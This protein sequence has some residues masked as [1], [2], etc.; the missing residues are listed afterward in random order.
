MAKKPEQKQIS[1][2]MPPP[3][4][5][6]ALHLGH[7]LNNF[8]QDALI[9]YY[10]LRN[11]QTIWIPGFDHAGIAT[12]IMVRKWM[13]TKQLKAPT[14][15]ERADLFQK[16]SDEQKTKIRQ[17][18]KKLDLK[19]N[20][21]YE[22]FTLDPAF[23]VV[24]TEAFTQLYEK[25]LIYQAKTLVNWDPFLE[26]AIADIEVDHRE[27]TTALYYFKYQLADPKEK[28]ETLIVATTRPETIFADQAVFVHPDDERYQ[29]YH[30]KYVINPLNQQ[31]LP[32]LTDTKI[33]RTF[34]SG[35]LKCTPGHDWIDWELGKKFNL[36]AINCIDARGYLNHLGLKYANK[37][38]F[39]ARQAIVS[40]AKKQGLIVKIETYQHKIP[41]SSRSGVV[42]EPLLSSQW[43]LKT[44]QWGQKLL[45]EQKNMHIQPN[46]YRK[47]LT[48]WLLKM[49]DWCIS[50][51]L[52]W[53]HQLPVYFHRQTQAIKVSKTPLE[54]KTWRRSSDVLDTWFSSA[55]WAVA[56]LGWNFPARQKL[57]QLYPLTY[58]VTS[59][60]IIF[61][62]VIKMLFFGLEFKHE[63]PFKNLIIHGLIRTKNHL[64]MSKSRGNVVNP[65]ELI[66]KYGVDALRW[67]FLTGYKIGDDLQFETEKIIQA[68]Q[69]V[70]KISNIEKF[71]DRFWAK[72]ETIGLKTVK[73]PLNAWLLKALKELDKNYEQHYPKLNFALIGDLLYDFIWKKFS[74]F[75]LLFCKALQKG[76]AANET[77]NFLKFVWQKLLC[78]LHPF[79]SQSSEK[80]FIKTFG[81]SLK[82]FQIET[83][84]P[85]LDCKT[86]KI[87]FF[88][89][90]LTQ[91]L[92]LKHKTNTKKNKEVVLASEGKMTENDL[93]TLNRLLATQKL[94]ITKTVIAKLTKL[95]LK[96]ASTD[97]NRFLIEQKIAALSKEVLRSE[98]ILNNQQFLS[99]AKATIVQAEKQ[100]YLKYKKEL[101]FW[102]A[103]LKF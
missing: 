21:E 34:G 31:K 28:D 50:R 92:A 30:Q 9:R 101:K 64:K 22:T 66:D 75:Y 16:W 85:K 52:Q 76:A 73:H 15:S 69:F 26:T 49:H 62:W 94:L 102:Q 93:A 87:K 17:Q 100:K 82:N 10:N 61:F 63:L 56:N 11:Y 5:T 86:E 72:S 58:L 74:N 65:M 45:L 41:Y 70:H 79:I 38:R 51:Q 77:K 39:I 96:T 103:K 18:W 36:K 78:Y 60:D 46:K 55:L 67:M 2:L 7:A 53:G 19:I 8:I 83:V 20:P 23:Q 24:V 14:Q 12:E 54:A 40:E 84:W 3:N 90:V 91:S 81:S 47:Y 33:D 32:I 80:L 48:N 99:N 43:F 6:G 97:Y 13:A 95:Q 37:E 57:Q 98:T 27:Q 59:Y 25:K 42:V 89:D 71:L 29:K 44:Q 4:V 88:N 35:V 1:I 68:R